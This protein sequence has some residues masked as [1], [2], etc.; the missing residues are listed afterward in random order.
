MPQSDEPS[1]IGVRLSWRCAECGRI[2]TT[3]QMV[4]ADAPCDVELPHGW[5]CLEG[6]LTVCGE[7][8]AGN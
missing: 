7:H 6:R 1:I 8:F 5:R 3:H 2:A 4:F